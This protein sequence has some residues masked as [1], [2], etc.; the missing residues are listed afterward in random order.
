MRHYIHTFQCKN[1]NICCVVFSGHQKLFRIWIV[2]VRLAFALTPHHHC[3]RFKFFFPLERPTFYCKNRFPSFFPFDGRISCILTA[4][5]V[6]SSI[7]M[8]KQ[9][10]YE[11]YMQ[12]L[13]HCVWTSNFNCRVL[14]YETEKKVM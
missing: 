14:K 9:I 11:D 3:K 13:C 1:V 2:R 6:T 8:F 12:R 5:D 7:S 4:F 10:R